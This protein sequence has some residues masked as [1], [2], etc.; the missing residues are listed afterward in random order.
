MGRGG[1]GESG[2]RE[3]RGKKEGR[4]GDGINLPHVRFKTLAALTAISVTLQW[5]QTGA[6]VTNTNNNHDH[7]H[8]DHINLYTVPK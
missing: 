5:S 7:H 8:H 3:G 2:R 4:G 6:E 1:D